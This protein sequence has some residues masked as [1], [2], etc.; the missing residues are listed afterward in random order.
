MAS[1]SD[2]PEGG[3]NEEFSDIIKWRS[4]MFFDHFAVHI[5]V[6]SL[7]SGVH[8]MQNCVCTAQCHVIFVKCYICA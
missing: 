1:S 3:A 5:G 7:R 4:G 6:L 8:C 2:I